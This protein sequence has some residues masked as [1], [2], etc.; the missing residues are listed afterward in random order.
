MS[1]EIRTP[2]T[3]ILGFAEVLREEGDIDSA[4]PHRIRAIDT[5]LSAGTHL[6]SLI[7]DILDLSKI[8]ADKMMVERIEMSPL[9]VLGEVHTLLAPKATGKGITLGLTF[10]SP[11]PERI[12]SDPTRLRQILMNLAGNAVKFTEAGSVTIL[13]GTDA[14]AGSPRL[15]IDIQDTGPGMSSEQVENLFKAFGQADESVTRKFGGTGLGLTICRRLAGLL[16]G[17]VQLL[18]TQPGK[19]SCFRLVLPLEAPPNT[20]MVDHLPDA[21]RARTPAPSKATLNGR[22][23]LAEDG[24]DNQRLICFHLRKAGATVNVADNGRIALEMIERAAGA[25]APYD[26]LLTDMQM[27]E[28][29]GY[30]LARALR[31]RGSPLPIVALTANAMAE[32]RARCLEA[33]C[34]DYTSKPIDKA[35]LLETCGRWITGTRRTL[36]E[37]KAA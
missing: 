14:G 24:P 9:A 8:E 23:L 10:T 32:D 3:A 19:G 31:T 20:A 12:M 36:T 1:H 21:G 2:L 6:L 34:D 30:T 13:V 33:G 29:D 35:A 27:P 17:D 37:P 7:N 18:H 25:R 5:I 15:T 28:M 16:D 11:V 22:I 4:P 26:M